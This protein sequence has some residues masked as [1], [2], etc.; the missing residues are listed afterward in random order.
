[1]SAHK[2]RIPHG[3]ESKLEA[4]VKHL[5]ASIFIQDKKK[6]WDPKNGKTEYLDK[7]QKEIATKTLKKS[8]QDI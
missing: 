7:V 1:M 4:S 2:I 3:L 5:N 8:Q 6:E